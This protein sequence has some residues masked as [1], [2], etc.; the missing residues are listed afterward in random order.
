MFILDLGSEFFPFGILDPWP[1]GFQ[2]PDPGS[3]TAS[4]NLSIF[5][6]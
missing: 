4:N 2:I 1:K 6:P 3:G 5:N